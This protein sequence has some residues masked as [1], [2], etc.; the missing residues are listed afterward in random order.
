MPTRL[1]NKVHEICTPS[2]LEVKLSK[3]KIMIFGLNKRE[4]SQEA[5]YLDKDQIETTHENKYIRLISIHMV[6]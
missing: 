2:S 3:T 6:A 5:F 1:L 4:S